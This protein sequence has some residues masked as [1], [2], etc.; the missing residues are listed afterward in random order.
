MGFARR[1]VRE[2]VR[3]ATPRPVRQAM[4]PARTVRYAVTPRPVKQVS[5]AAY[6]VRHPVGAAEN[7]VIGATL[8]A[9]TGHRRS[10]RSGS[11]RSGFWHWL[12][13]GFEQPDPS[14]AV[15]ARQPTWPHSVA[16]PTR[17]APPAPRQAAPRR[18]QAPQPWPADRAFRGNPPPITRPAPPSDANGPYSAG[19]WELDVRRTCGLGDGSLIHWPPEAD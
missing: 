15:P 9:G 6:T 12:L 1:A 2:S 16:P 3:W 17:L 10:Q 5:R 7:K 4:H 11:K 18:R 19:E 8:N 14:A 13:G